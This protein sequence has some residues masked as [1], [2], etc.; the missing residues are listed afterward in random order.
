MNQEIRAQFPFLNRGLI[1]LDTAATSL[2]PEMVI[3]AEADYYRELGVNTGRG[4]SVH[5]FE[6][7]TGLEDIRSRVASF[8]GSNDK[9]SIIF[10]QNSTDSIN[11]VAQSLRKYLVTEKTNIVITQL[12]HH[13][14]YTPWLDLAEELGIK[15]RVIPLKG[16]SID[17]N[18]LERYIDEDTI[19]T[20]ITGMSNLT[21]E[22]T[23]IER[24]VSRVRSTGGKVLIDGAQLIC[25]E[26]V[27]VENLDV[28]Y[29]CFS[30][31]KL[32]GPFG[33]GI[34][35]GKKELLEQMKPG[36]F[37]GNMV[38]YINNL[39]SVHYKPVPT[40]FESG[41]QNPAAIYGFNKSLDF[42]ESINMKEREK[43]YKTLALKLIDGLKEIEGVTIYSNPGAIISFNIEG[44]HPHDA[45]EFF[46]RAGIIIRTG[47]LCASPFF[48]NIE[49][50]GVIRVS[51]G[52]Y[53]S[54]EDIVK[55][56]E[57]VREIKEFFL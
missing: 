34:L 39:N 4:S 40:R 22:K 8:M 38:S 29:F 41:T 19:I 3:T 14:N 31:H 28:D 6:T 42:I 17:Y 47:N 21:G 57:T 30:T 11:L 23:D 55:V 24:V 5:N 25:H 52:I 1:Y 54:A 46:D 15:C 51:L 37:G 32:Y 10:T 27:D 36:R 44:V 56:L 35:Y 9:D 2:K 49:E 43:Y 53:N 48:N 16:Y 7:T 45:S 13:S 26:D 50:S 33:L 12:E 20:A 18:Y